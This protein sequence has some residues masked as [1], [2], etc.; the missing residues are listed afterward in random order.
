[1]GFCSVEHKR[2]RERAYDYDA[3]I[4]LLNPREIFFKR[5][6]AIIL[7]VCIVDTFDIRAEILP[8]LFTRFHARLTIMGNERKKKILVTRHKYTTRSIFVGKSQ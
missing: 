1:M 8:L 5:S 6:Q 7:W 2:H 3:A 4:L